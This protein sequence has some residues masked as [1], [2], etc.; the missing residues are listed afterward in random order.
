MIHQLS[1]IPGMSD[2]EA[3]LF[4]INSGGNNHY[5]KEQHKIFLYHRGNIEGIKDDLVS[6]QNML[7]NPHLR[8]VEDNW[9]HFRSS[10][11]ATIVEHIP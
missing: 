2:H 10:L 5:A 7:C 11:L 1:V 6:F 8:S 3:L 4:G 9:N